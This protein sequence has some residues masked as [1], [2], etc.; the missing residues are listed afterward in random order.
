MLQEILA[1]ASMVPRI[2][3]CK[4]ILLMPP[5]IDEVDHITESM[6]AMNKAALHGIKIHTMHI[7]LV[8]S[9]GFP[10]VPTEDLLQPLVYAYGQCE[11]VATVPV[12]TPVMAQ[13]FTAAGVASQDFKDVVLSRC[14]IGVSV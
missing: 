7:Y 2:R 5:N 9:F 4:K 11:V 10:T 14:C 6:V 3:S 13:L 12:L 1:C 8:F